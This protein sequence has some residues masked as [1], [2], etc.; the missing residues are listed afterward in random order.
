MMFQIS[1]VALT[2]GYFLGFANGTIYTGATKAIC[3]PGLNCYSCPGALGSCPIGAL[4]NVLANR[5][6]QFTF[7]VVGFLMITGAIFGRFVCGWLCPFGLA[8]DLLFKIPFLKK[9][10]KVRGDKILKY[11]KFVMLA[12]FVIILPLFIVDIVGQGSPWFCE[13]V[14]PAGTL[15]AGWPL[16]AA[17]PS[18]QAIVGGLY[19]WKNFILITI[20][21]LSILIYRPFCRYV[22]PLGAV[23]E[24]TQPISL[25][26][27]RIDQDACTKCGVCKKTCK[28]DISIF[29]TP[30]SPE[31]IRCG[32]CLKACPENAISVEFL[33]RKV[34][35]RKVCEK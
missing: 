13:W 33:K 35:K 28:L 27:Y 14:C 21:V 15:M 20:I 22:C 29:E 11:I 1:Y 30:N 17:N 2:N 19:A 16:V 12:L 24:L 26:R 6:F 32:D 31:C 10:R 9:I 4:Q 25:Y 3:V 8:Q 34:K 5:N 23:Y 18:L 7:Y